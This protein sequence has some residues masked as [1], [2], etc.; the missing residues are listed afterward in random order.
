[1]LDERDALVTAIAESYLARS[2]NK[3]YS[4]GTA[5]TLAEAKLAKHEDRI[6]KEILRTR[7]CPHCG[8]SITD[9]RC[10]RQ[11]LTPDPVSLHGTDH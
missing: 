6:R 9:D 10:H 4:L 7:I 8:S 5:A 1:M 2:T 3:G 11:S